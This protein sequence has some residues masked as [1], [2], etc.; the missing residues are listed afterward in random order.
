MQNSLI[1][2][3]IAQGEKMILLASDY[4]NTLKREKICFN[5][6]SRI[7]DFRSAGNKFG[8]VTGRS[9]LS[10]EAE[11]KRYRIPIDF[12]V[13]VNGGLILDKDY[14][15]LKMTTIKDDVVTNLI[16]FI[17]NNKNVS[18]FYGNI[19]ES[20]RIVNDYQNPNIK[21]QQ[22]QLKNVLNVGMHTKENFEMQELVNDLSQQFGNDLEFNRNGNTLVDINAFGANKANGINDY[23][24][25]TNSSFEK[26]FVVG[27][28]YNDIPMLETFD[29]FAIKT[30]KTEVMS[31]AKRIVSNIHEVLDYI[32]NEI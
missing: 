32:N 27:D 9:F 17:L 24:N 18:G 4:D 5:E 11:I 30:H 25:L 3:I 28:S 23:I 29:S 7:Y 31:A 26:I 8:L 1:Y 14:N 12:L 6:L 19:E 13:C 22:T 16:S 10:I 15:V 21:F 20:V 2:I